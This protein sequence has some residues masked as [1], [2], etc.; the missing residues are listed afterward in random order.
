MAD[1]V[2]GN[3]HRWT[4]E[5]IREPTTQVEDDIADL[6]RL[7]PP[8]WEMAVIACCSNQRPNPTQCHVMI[9]DKPLT[10]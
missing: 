2:L 5:G 7:E 3:R 9:G 6:F 4:V 1:G 8:Q 10:S